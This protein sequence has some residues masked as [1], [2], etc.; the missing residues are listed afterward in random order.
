MKVIY[1]VCFIPP[2]FPRFLF[3]E[4]KNKQFQSTSSFKFA[5]FFTSLGCWSINKSHYL[6]FHSF[7]FESSRVL[8][9]FFPSSLLPFFPSSLLPFF[10]SFFLSFF[11][12]FGRHS[13]DF[14]K[15][16]KIDKVSLSS[17]S[18]LFL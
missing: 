18:R 6:S 16:K 12:P 7:P 15:G 17:T 13:I 2:L 10:L 3:C 14:H 8:L 11:L 4:E 5:L 1:L 9:P